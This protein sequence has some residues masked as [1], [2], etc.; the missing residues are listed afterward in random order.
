M[1]YLHHQ[2][3]ENQNNAPDNLATELIAL[4]HYCIIHETRDKK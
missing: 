3:K 2:R 4:T 1:I